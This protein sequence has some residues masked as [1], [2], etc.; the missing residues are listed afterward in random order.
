[1]IRE[2]AVAGTFYSSNPKS[3]QQTVSSYLGEPSERL[4]AMG[5][6]GPH[7]GYMYS[8]AVAGSVYSAVELPRRFIILGPNHTGR[9]APWALHPPGDWRTPLGLAPVDAELNRLLLQE[10][11][12]LREDRVAHFREHSI[13]VHIPFLQVLLHDFTFAAISVGRTDFAALEA[14]GHA[15]ARVVQ[16]AAQPVLL[17]ASSDMT[18]YE[19]ADTAAR[20]D[21]M[22]IERVLKLDPRGLH[23]VVLEEDISMCGLAPAVAL[24]TACCDLGAT[25]GKLIR[26]SNSGDT[27]GDYDHVVGY[28]G[29]AII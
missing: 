23:Q 27:S 14:L 12:L 1:M 6:I 16:A 25:A 18:H 9:G 28:A 19:P 29:M 5:V 24:L 15:L 8:G 7:A 2:P 20:K 10:C 26:Y 13:E 22:A 11:S 21:R 17:I 3:L 4:E